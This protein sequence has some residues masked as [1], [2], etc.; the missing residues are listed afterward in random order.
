MNKT[1]CLILYW[2]VHSISN[3]AINCQHVKAFPKQFTHHCNMPGPTTT[4]LLKKV[5]LQRKHFFD[6]IGA[7]NTGSK[8]INFIN[9]SAC[10]SIIVCNTVFFA[11]QSFGSISKYFHQNC[12]HC[13]RM[14][15]TLRWTNLK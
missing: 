4:I 11:F 7:A 9:M 2:L 5:S 15:F 14:L 13:C 6:T 1:N 10:A 12:T 3:F 8:Q